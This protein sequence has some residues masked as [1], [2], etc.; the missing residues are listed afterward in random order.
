MSFIPVMMYLTGLAV[1]GF[2][3][4]LLDGIEKIFV[5]TGLA[6]AGDTY[7]ILLYLWLGIIVVYVLFGGIW[8]IRSYNESVNMGRMY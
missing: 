6:V 5:G 1:F 7:D 3:Y 4:W 8:L 2:I